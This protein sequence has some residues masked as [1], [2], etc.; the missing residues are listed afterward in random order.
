MICFLLLTHYAAVEV[1]LLAV[2]YRLEVLRVQLLLEL[3]A[4]ALRFGAVPCCIGTLRPVVA[5]VL[6]CCRGQR[7]IGYRTCNE[8]QCSSQSC[9][10]PSF[11]AQMIWVQGSAWGPGLGGGGC[12]APLVFAARLW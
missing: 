10:S 4:L 11:W 5:V 7:C 8:E 6:S 2:L 3:V 1:F 12:E 9:W